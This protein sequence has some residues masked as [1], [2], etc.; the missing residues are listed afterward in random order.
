MNHFLA[1]EIRHSCSHPSSGKVQEILSRKY[2]RLL[3][4]ILAHSLLSTPQMIFKLVR[5]L[6]VRKPL[7]QPYSGLEKGNCTSVKN[8]LT[9]RG[10]DLISIAIMR[11]VVV[12]KLGES[13]YM[14]VDCVDIQHPG[15]MT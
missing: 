2:T 1:C 3:W 9:Q 15:L 8:V 7:D 4:T 6:V 11:N 10:G 13:H 14:N 5:V 12:K